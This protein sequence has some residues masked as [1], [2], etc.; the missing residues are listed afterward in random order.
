MPLKPIPL[1]LM[2]LTSVSKTYQKESRNIV[3][4]HTKTVQASPAS[5]PNEEMA[6]LNDATLP[7][8]LWHT[9]ETMGGLR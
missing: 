3:L 2:L 6:S 7:S 4:T 5:G 8:R 9:P 1:Q